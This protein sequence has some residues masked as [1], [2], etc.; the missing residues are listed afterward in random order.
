MKTRAVNAMRS[1]DEEHQDSEQPS[2]LQKYDVRS[3]R[4]ALLLLRTFSLEEPQ[5]SLRELSSHLRLSTSTTFRLVSTLEHER[6]VQRDKRT[7]KYSLGLACLELGSVCRG[8]IRLRERILLLLERLRN[9]CGETVH[10]G[11][12]DKETMEVV[13]IEKLEGLLPIIYM[14]SQVG[15]RSPAYC[16]GLGKALLAYEDPETVSSFYS[17]RGLRRYTPNTIV[18]VDELVRHL[19][20][21]RERGFGIDDEEHELGVKCIAAPVWDGRGEVC[22]AFSV[23]GPAQ[24]V[25]A[26]IA[27]G[28][29]VLAVKRIVE[30]MAARPGGKSPLIA[31]G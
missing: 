8:S 16:T 17:R 25:T 11:T 23:S 1:R 30:E 31:G 15:G 7:G 6:F 24:R 28:S 20:G 9:E 3:V 12:L 10:L 4:R 5:L 21:I 19:A 22:A 26:A 18:G 13:Y 27:D 29:L 14:A 2:E